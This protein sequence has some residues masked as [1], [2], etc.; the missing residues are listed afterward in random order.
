[1]PTAG[2]DL[3]RRLNRGVKMA[4]KNADR[5]ELASNVGLGHAAKSLAES[6]RKLGA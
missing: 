2:D 1:M 4:Q 6:H 3:F 5:V